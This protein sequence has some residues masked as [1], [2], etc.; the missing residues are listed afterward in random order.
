MNYCIELASFE[1]QEDHVKSEKRARVAEYEQKHQMD[2]SLN[3]GSALNEKTDLSSNVTANGN[4]TE[5]VGDN[6]ESGEFMDA[7]SDEDLFAPES[8]AV[9]AATKERVESTQRPRQARQGARCPIPGYNLV[10][11]G[12]QLYEPYLQRPYPPTDD[13]IAERRM[14]LSRSHQQGI[15]KRLEVSYRLQK[16]KLLS[17]MCAFKAANPG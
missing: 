7:V 16:P 10:G 13:F 15:H 2:D 5:M 9:A 1:T 17:D 6:S 11:T 3:G 14:M 12:D 4:S 8:A